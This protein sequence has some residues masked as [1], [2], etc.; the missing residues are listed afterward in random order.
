[1]PDWT[2]TLEAREGGY[3]PGF[4]AINSPLEDQDESEGGP[5]VPPPADEPAPAE[6]TD[7]TPPSDV[8]ADESP[9]SSSSRSRSR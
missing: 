7:T 2:H 1:M 5:N 3:L 8:T 4:L 6:P 9:T